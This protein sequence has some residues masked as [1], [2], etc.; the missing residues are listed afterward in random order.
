MEINCNGI[1]IQLNKQ[2]ESF[3]TE[4][5]CKEISSG[6]FHVNY[7]F[8]CSEPT[9]LS[10]IKISWVLPSVDFHYKWNSQCMQNRA[11]D[12]GLGTFNYIECRSS[13][14]APVYSLYNLEG[15]NALT[16]ALSD[17]IHDSRIGGTTENGF[18]YNCNITVNGTK[19]DPTSEYSLTL[20]LDFRKVPYY[21]C[22]QETSLWW[23]SFPTYKPCKI[24][25][26]AKAPLIC[27]WYIYI[28]N[29]DQNDLLKQCALA[30]KA[31][32]DV[33]ILDDGWQTNQLEFGYQNNGDWEVCKDKF[34]DFKSY[35]KQVQDV[36]MKFLVWFSIPYVGIESKIYHKMKDYLLPAREGAKWFSFDPRY[37]EVRE[38]LSSKFENFVLEYGIDGLKMDFIGTFGCNSKDEEISK[39]GH[40]TISIGV[41]VCKLLDDVMK[42]LYAINP[43]ILIEFRQEYVGPAMR[44][45]G[46]M[47]RAVDCPNSIGDNRVRTI[48]TRLLSGNT[49]VHSDPITWHKKDTVES[50]AMQLIH[51]LFSVPQLSIKISDLP[52]DHSK[53]LSHYLSFWKENRQ[54]L[55]EGELLPLYPNQLYPMVIAKDNQKCIVAFYAN[56]PFE[57]KEHIN[58][59]LIIVNGTYKEELLIDTEIDLGN[60]STI[61]YTCTGKQINEDNI[62]ISKGISKVKVPIAGQLILNRL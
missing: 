46:N 12:A 38:Y 1:S 34:P 15:T 42:R 45:Y 25:N 48:D 10:D 2:I 18:N 36:G 4:L 54:V 47:F 62:Q 35:V 29:V 22:L 53:M 17:A 16:F 60:F 57:C 33:M 44:K 52:A 39:P 37:P 59:T 23:E 7:H 3:E 8:T 11:L 41:A 43:N 31:G 49:A 21:Q 55:L 61:S 13:R 19:I 50:A 24:P 40:D 58:K 28:V 30:K 56:T 32:I 20:R 9:Q 26:E 51:A 6:V 14:Q 27:S 5:T